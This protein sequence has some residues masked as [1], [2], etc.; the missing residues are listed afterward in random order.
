MKKFLVL[1]II[2]AYGVNANA[3]SATLKTGYKAS[4]IGIF[5]EKVISEHASFQ[6]N[7]SIF[8]GIEEI[9]G[10]AYGFGGGY[11]IYITNKEAPR[12]FYL[13]PRAGATF[14]ENANSVSIGVDLGYQW[15]WKSGIVI[16]LGLGPNYH[17]SLEDDGT[18]V[19]DGVVPNVVAALGYSF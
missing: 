18:E 12:G 8:F 14:G 2:L 15:I 13:M 19:F 6:I 7:G 10:S 9:E 5:Y 11:K 17:K 1:I 16:D 3:Q 4:A